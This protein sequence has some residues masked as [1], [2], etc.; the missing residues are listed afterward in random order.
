M[1]FEIY[2]DESRPELFASRNSVRGKY[3]LIGGL[4]IVADSRAALKSR[5]RELREEHNVKG[6]F[7]WTL[8]YMSYLNRLRERRRCQVS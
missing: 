5:I 6:E 3:V 4:W 8:G 1:D 2:C 7:K